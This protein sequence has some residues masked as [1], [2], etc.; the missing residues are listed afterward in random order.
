MASAVK[1]LCDK[2]YYQDRPTSV[3]ERI[4][5]YLVIAFPSAVVNRE[6]DPSGAYNDYTTTVLLYVYVRDRMS[7]SNPAAIDLAVMDEKVSAA[8]KVFPVDN[9][10]FRVVRPELVMQV[11]DGSGFHVAIIR[12][13]L[14]TK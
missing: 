11:N 13:R 1:G 10:L 14:R 6:L 5:S 2:T 9:D 12:A 8:M 4:A 7:A 3:D